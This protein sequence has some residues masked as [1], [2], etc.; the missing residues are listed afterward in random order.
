[1]NALDYGY[2]SLPRGASAEEIARRLGVP[3][4]SFVDHLRK[5][6]NKVMQAMASYLRLQLGEPQI[7]VLE[8]RTRNA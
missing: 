2:Y 8:T 4:T 5:A 1:M 3:R 7:N 6:E